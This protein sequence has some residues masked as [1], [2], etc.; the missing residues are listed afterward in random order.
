MS[1][2]AD[3]KEVT[4]QVAGLTEEV[5]L[6]VHQLKE[7]GHAHTQTVIHKSTGISAWGAAAVVACFATW[8]GLVFVMM[9]IHDLRAWKDI[10]GRDLSAIKQIIIQ[11]QEKPK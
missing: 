7:S 1:A 5:R 3:L 6:L 2:A 11:Q 4:Q 8:I 9:D 10:Y